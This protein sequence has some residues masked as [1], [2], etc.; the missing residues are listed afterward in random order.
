MNE[1]QPLQKKRRFTVTEKQRTVV[2]VLLF[3]FAVVF[4]FWMKNSYS[5]NFVEDF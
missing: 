3:L 4:I 2:L 1:E 5:V